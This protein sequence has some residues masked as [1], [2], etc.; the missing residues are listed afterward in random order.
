[1]RHKRVNKVKPMIVEMLGFSAPTAKPTGKLGR[2]FDLKVTRATISFLYFLF[3]DN[4][5]NSAYL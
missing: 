1:V 2:G 5:L 3:G 4:Y